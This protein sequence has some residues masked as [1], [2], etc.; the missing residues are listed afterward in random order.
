MQIKYVL[1]YRDCT[2][3]DE[4]TTFDT[5]DDLLDQIRYEHE[6]VLETDSTFDEGDWVT[7]SIEMTN[8]TAVN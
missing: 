4:R 6:C 1:T 5:L 3:C 8:I 2:G 7:W